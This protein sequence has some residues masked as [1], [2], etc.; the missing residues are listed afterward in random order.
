[1]LEIFK[2]E[3]IMLEILKIEVIMLEMLKIEAIMLEILT[4]Y[5]FLSFFFLFFFTNVCCDSSCLDF[6]SF[7]FLYIVGSE[8]RGNS[9]I[10]TFF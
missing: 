6:T 10:K 3:V 2:I 7:F 9:L 5:V 8:L 1:M 4:L